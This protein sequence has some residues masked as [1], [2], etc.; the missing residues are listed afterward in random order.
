MKPWAGKWAAGTREKGLPGWLPPR[1]P[2]ADRQLG[3]QGPETLSQPPKGDP[4]TAGAFPPEFRQTLSSVPA[5]LGTASSPGPMPA[6]WPE[7]TSRHPPSTAP[8]PH[9]P[10]FP[11]PN[12]ETFHPCLHPQHPGCNLPQHPGSEISILLSPGKAAFLFSSEPWLIQAVFCFL[13]HPWVRGGPEGG[14][15]PPCGRGQYAPTGVREAGLDGSACAIQASDAR[16]QAT[17]TPG[18][19]GE[20][21]CVLA[22]PAAASS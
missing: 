21:D 14:F 5:G 1:S 15:S 18:P 22:S 20:A 13:L 12:P 8:P 7:L 6:E 3:P 16:A 19:G 17:C 9:V 4:Q 10:A 2:R 11:S